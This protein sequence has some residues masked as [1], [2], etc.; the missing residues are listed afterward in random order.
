MRDFALSIIIPVYNG[1]KTIGKLIEALFQDI[2][3][4]P[5][6]IIMV[7]DGSK[8]DSEVVCKQLCTRYP[9][10][11][12]ISLR[13][14]AG[15]FVAVFCGLKHAIGNYSVII[16]DD[17]QHAPSEIIKLY[18]HII[19]KDLDVV[20][21]DFSKK[22]HSLFRNI[23]SKISNLLANILL[24]KPKEIY[25]SSFKILHKDLIIEI[26]KMEVQFPYLDGMI[27]RLTQSVGSVPIVHHKRMEGQS[28]YT[29]K[30]LFSYFLQTVFSQS[31][32]T[33]K[34][35][36][37]IGMLLIPVS[38]L[39]FALSYSLFISVV[40]FFTGLQFLGLYVLGEYLGSIYFTSQKQSPFSI[41]TIVKS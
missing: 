31:I 19:N 34:L 26:A 4:I 13:K 24:D 20:F 15:E 18:N 5:F 23:G 8:D 17:F 2:Q 39:I 9:N 14:N 1:S 36:G 28:N 33:L 7:N 16:D 30:K 6:E 11:T 25:L 41:K 12:F 37:F 38:V 29:F 10:I 32:W 3:E 27:F 22:E 40:I 21:A 35:L